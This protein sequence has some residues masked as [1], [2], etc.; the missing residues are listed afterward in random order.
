VN[1]VDTTETNEQIYESLPF[2]IRTYFKD[3][4]KYTIK[5]TSEIAQKYDMNKITMEQQIHLLKADDSIKEKAMTKLKEIKGK[6][7]EFGSKAKQYL[8]GLLKIPFHVYREE[9]ILKKMKELNLWYH[10]IEAI[11]EKLFPNIGLPVSIL[12]KDIK[13]QKV[14]KKKKKYTVIEIEQNILYI[15]NFIDTHVLSYIEKYLDAFSTKQIAQ[16]VKYINNYQKIKKESSFIVKNTTKPGQIKNI[17]VFF[18]TNKLNS[19][20]NQEKL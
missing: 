16:M 11:I 1:T 6:S 12:E 19:F 18:K 9:P 15:E 17:L 20:V 10:N 8:D 13:I 2:K 14:L 4:I 7:E 3:V 5:N